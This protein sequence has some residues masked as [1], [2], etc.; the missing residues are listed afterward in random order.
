MLFFLDIEVA[1]S[2]LGLS[3]LTAKVYF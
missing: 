1:Y 3:S 2:F